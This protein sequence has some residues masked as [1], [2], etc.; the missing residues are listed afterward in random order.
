MPAAESGAINVLLVT[1]PDAEQSE[2]VRAIDPARLSVTT[3]PG[4]EFAADE[5]TLWPPHGPLAGVH[6]RSREER[7]AILR[8]VHVILLGFPVPTRLYARTRSL[9]WVHHPA[10]GASNLRASDFWGAPVTVTTSRGANAALPIAETAI[11]GALMLAKGLHFAA[12]GSMD[13]GDYAQNLSVAGKTMG[14]LGLGGIGG[15]IARLARG[16]GMRV[17]AT[18]RSAATREV[19]VQGVAEL[20]PASELHAM[21][22]Q[23]DYLAICAMLTAETEG[24]MNSHAFTALKKGAVLVNVARGEIVDEEAMLASLNS[25]RLR[26]AYLDVYAGELSGREPPPELQHHP[27]VVM[28]PHTSG[29]ADERGAVGFDLFLENLQ[30]VL[31]SEPMKNVVDWERG[32]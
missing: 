18:R 19:D 28:T 29:R 8:D 32:Y 24:M 21:L 9:E 31:V 22:A 1:A 10:A 6:A 3:I 30:R 4:P 16:L 7:D 23:S 17:V 11:G 12:R 14:I 5:G 2:R 13:R 25:G 27:N 15:H 26:G 20:F